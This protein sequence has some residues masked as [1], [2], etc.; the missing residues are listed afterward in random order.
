VQQQFT[1]G[2]AAAYLNLI[3]Q[4]F[5]HQRNA[6]MHMHCQGSS[7]RSRAVNHPPLCCA[8]E[9]QLSDLTVT[10]HSGRPCLALRHYSLHVRVRVR[11]LGCKMIARSSSAARNGG[12]EYGD[13]AEYE[14]GIYCGLSER[15]HRRFA[16]RSRRMKIAAAAAA[17]T[18][19][20]HRI[21]HIHHSTTSLITRPPHVRSPNRVIMPSVLPLT[22]GVG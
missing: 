17:A 3:T 9:L 16:R 15:R 5:P 6:G 4:L 11:V 14:Q 20:C 2:V 22:L 21:A 19:S 13:D 12:V 10:E 8:F 1:S 18:T 7:I